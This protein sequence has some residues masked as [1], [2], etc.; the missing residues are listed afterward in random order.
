MSDIVEFSLQGKEELFTKLNKILSGINGYIAGGVFKDILT[1]KEPKDV[2]VYFE[3]EKDYNDALSAT[4]M[5]QIYE[6]Q[7]VIGFKTID[8]INVEYVHSFY[9]KPEELIN[10]FDFTITK[11]AYWIKDGVPT[12]I[13]HTDFETDLGFKNLRVIGNLPFPVSTFMRA[14]RYSEY[15]Y[16]LDADSAYRIVKAVN[17]M[18]AIDDSEFM[19]GFYGGH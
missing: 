16:W 10:E 1:G 11:F 3:T 9:K 18:P 12:A 14:I 5:R 17:E 7:N 6:S 19:S 2:D 13:A 4:D 8:S 15:G